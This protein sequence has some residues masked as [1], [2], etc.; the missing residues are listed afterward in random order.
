[1]E[2]F[3]L[4]VFATIMFGIQSF[5]YKSSMEK[6]CN[7]F[8]VTLS[9]MVTVE[10]LAVILFLF[11]GINFSSLLITLVLGFVFAIVFYIK[12]ISQMKALQFLPTNKVFPITASEV[13][14]V[15]IFALIFFHETLE[16][17]QIIGITMII[18]S[19]T[20]I[21]SRSKKQKDYSEKKIGFFY[22][23]L[24]IPF[25]A[26]VVITNKFATMNSEIGFFIV[27]AYLFSILI[28]FISYKVAE[29]NSNKKVSK[30]DSLKIGI[31]IGIVNFLGFFAFLTA[32]KTGPLA[33]V[34]AIHPNYIIVTV[35]LA[36]IVHKEEL[37]WK[38]FGLVVLSVIGIILLKI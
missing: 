8:L 34:S 23:F 5:L 18:L 32:L 17:Y 27:I 9:F 35:I 36:R 31:F 3:I 38:Q 16:L 30:K 22:A 21:H 1:M 13:I 6:G 37:T 15:I 20:L 2:W 29:E 26:A 19:I 25:G 10:I 7:K 28:S 33:L 24:A 14:L 12:T 4:S 11:K